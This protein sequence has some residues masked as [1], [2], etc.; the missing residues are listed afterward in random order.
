[1]RLIEVDAVCLQ[2]PQR[3]LHGAE[4]V[5]GLEPLLVRRHLHAD[6]GR[7]HDFVALAGGL[8]PLSDDGLGLAACVSR[9]PYRIDVGRID[10]FEAG[11]D[12]RVEQAE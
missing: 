5:V 11:V 3:I 12:E 2:S 4:D 8:Q 10:E 6:F 1:M 9:R 7:Q